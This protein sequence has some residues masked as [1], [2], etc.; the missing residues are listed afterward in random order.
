MVKKTAPKKK[1]APKKKAAPKKAA[2]PR[3]VTFT[4]LASAAL[5]TQSPTSRLPSTAAPV[6]DYDGGR[7][8]AVMPA[9][10]KPR[11]VSEHPSGRRWMLLLLLTVGRE[12]PMRNVAPQTRRHAAKRCD[13]EQE[14]RS[15]RPALS[16]SKS[17]VFDNRG[18]G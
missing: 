10:L 12:S 9:Q 11:S 1:P 2:Y 18:A 7:R 14:R 17:L 15:H 13:L 6:V 4:S 8:V 3:T 16:N 5:T